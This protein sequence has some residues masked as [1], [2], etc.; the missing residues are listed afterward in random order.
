M[1]KL[2]AVAFLLLRACIPVTAADL[3]DR[4]EP[5]GE[6][7]ISQ[8]SLN[9]LLMQEKEPEVI[10]MASESAPTVP[11]EGG[12]PTVVVRHSS[13]S[14]LT[15]YLHG[16][17]VTSFTTP[18]GQ[19]LLL[20]SDKAVFDG[21]KPIRGGIPIAFPQF[22]AQGPLPMHGFARTS[23]WT[24]LHVGDG[25]IE[26]E[27]K[28]SDA[29]RQAWPHAF[30]LVYHI[31]FDDS[32]LTCALDVINPE[33]SAGPFSFEALLHGYFRLSYGE[34]NGGVERARIAGLA[35]VTYIDK[36]DNMSQHVQGEEPI[37][38]GN[39]VDRIYMDTPADVKVEGVVPPVELTGTGKPYRSFTV[40]RNAAVRDISARGRLTN[41][42][43]RA[44]LDVVVWNPGA[45]K[46][47][48]IVDLGEG[49]WKQYVCVE[50]GRVS[51]ATK[52]FPA[53]AALQPGH[54][55]KLTQTVELHYD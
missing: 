41:V 27:L 16:A 45:V 20:V 33:G 43:V 2:L 7:N 40:K 5:K 35:G 1:L 49:Q 44:P 32:H 26:L 8:H 11:G 25:H 17:T 19:E 18:A 9:P 30:R 12:L 15:V 34:D 10:N 54:S 13:G 4:I 55:W 39:E 51:P 42:V 47:G 29:T 3:D 48:A 52:D 6:H 31:Q 46:A 38:L 28:D 53:H 50:P 14:R 37:R 24:P 36:P 21:V 23:T 22:A